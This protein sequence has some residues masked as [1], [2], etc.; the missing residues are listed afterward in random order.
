M[1]RCAKTLIFF[2]GC[3]I[4]AI[5]AVSLLFIILGAI[6]MRG[7]P[8]INLEFI[9]AE[10]RNFGQN[11]GIL[12]QTAGTLI[13][14]TGAGI[15]SLPLS[16]STAIYQTEYINVYFRRFT[17]ILIYALNGVPTIIF[18]LF[19]YM[20]FGLYFKMEVSWMTGISILAIMISP[21]LTVSVKESIEMIPEKYREAG[22]ALG[23]TKWKIIR[24]IIIPH[25]FFGIITGLLLGLGRAA[26]ET[27]A[28]MFTATTF[29]G[30]KFPTS[31]REPVTTLQTHILVLAQEAVNPKTRTNAWGAA[32]VLVVIIFF[33]SLCAMVIRTRIKQ[34]ARH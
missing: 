14:I 24:T 10:S 13:L 9:T 16:V 25:S 17:N 3:T 31:F 20:V 29:S 7:L 2:S 27:A 4:A 11:G 12:Y 15:L 19:G 34:E 28:I 30:V 26:G 32:L 22:L 33:I 5:I 21:T 18:G 8:A 23:F 6:V 1:I